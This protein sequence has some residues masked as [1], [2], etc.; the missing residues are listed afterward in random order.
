MTAIS[1]RIPTAS[2]WAIS[3]NMIGRSCGTVTRQ[4]AAL[5]KNAAEPVEALHLQAL[6]LVKSVESFSLGGQEYATEDD[7]HAP[8]RGCGTCMRPTTPPAPRAT[9][10]LRALRATIGG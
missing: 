4:N 3:A 10:L 2:H 6:R 1:L 7:A 9:N 5:S 8:P